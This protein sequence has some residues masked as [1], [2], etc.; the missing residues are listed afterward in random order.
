MGLRSWLNQ[1]ILAFLNDPLPRYEQRGWN[2]PAALARHIRIG[3]V[4]LVTGDTRIA[5]IIRYLTQSAWSHA[6]LY[7]GDE[8]LR[9]G[10]ER[11]RALERR[12]GRD[13]ARLVIEALPEGV[14][15][16]PLT[17]YV[18]YN[19]RLVRAHGL[20][21]EDRDR[22]VEDAVGALGW[23]Y[24]VR[25]VLDLARY[26]VPVTL[27]PARFRRNA[28]RFG[29]GV[30]TE[31][32]CSSLIGELF[33]RVRFPILPPSELP[34]GAGAEAPLPARVRFLRRVL[35]RRHR[36]YSPLF[37][38]RH[39]TLLTP[40]DFDLSPYFEV[41]KFNVIA[42]GDFDYRQI[43]WEPE[44]VAAPLETTAEAVGADLKKDA[45]SHG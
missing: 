29:S 38:F 30:P 41:V 1:R 42:D 28:L 17:K 37:R 3:D 19:I 12:Y 34:G 16:T 8:L 32:I 7:V 14:V 35:R 13:A 15:A 21:R 11:A 27:V 6:A 5:A 33:Q 45:P 18:D 9:R 2:D 31:V 10:G 25:N 39:P 23:R 22:I 20:R 26:L 44:P 36:D 24:D 43:R 4:L 40:A